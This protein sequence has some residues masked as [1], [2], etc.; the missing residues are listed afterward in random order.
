MRDENKTKEQLA[1]ELTE[2][3]QR[4]A[5]LEASETER[6]RAESQREATLEALRETRDYLENLINYA[7]APII[8]W[9]PG[10]R[11]TRFNTAFEHLTGYPADEVIGQELPMLFPETSRAESL[12]KI[13]RTLGGEYW[14][15]VEIPI[16]CQDGETRLVL[17]NSANI[18]AEDGTTL[19]ATISQGTDITER[20]HA[21]G[22]LREY[23]ERLEEIVEERTQELREREQWLSTTLRSIGDGV[24]ATDAQGVVTLMNPVAEDL[25]GWEEA[26][27]VGKP[28]EGIFCIVNEQTGERVE[29]PVARVL[30]EGVVVGLANHT[31][32]IA[33]DG[34]GRPIADSGAPMQDEAGKIIG[35]VMVFRDI[36][37]RRRA[38]RAVEEA[39]EFAENIVETV[40]EPL[41]VLDADLRVVSANRPFHQTFQVTPAETKGQLLY[42]LGNRQWNIPRLRELLERI[43]PENTFFDDYEVEH[44]FPSI[45]RRVILL[46]ARRMYRE[47][48]ETQ[49]VLLAIEDITERVQAEGELRRHR[50]HLEELVEQRTAELK[51]TNEE[52]ETEIA[53]RVR[54]EEEL[55]RQVEELERFNRL[56]VGREL[57][58]I[59]LKRQVNQ[60]SEQL[61]RDTAYDL[62]ILE[63]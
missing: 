56:A 26:E 7:N 53:E 10:K 33:R 22:Q 24:I 11:I 25:T 38:E 57:R 16:L 47:A 3:R 32:L 27:A 62:S 44:D 5:G 61:G 17:W 48:N 42:D 63:G 4:I 51:G 37:A 30:R 28:L 15:S 18:Y 21:E 31:L 6:T 60:L 29:S 45:G 12:G 58:M 8:I 59:E 14:K 2:L 55:A 9:D 41:V 49:L 23:S 19:V 46:N 1:E 36:T 40:R 39:R 43:L 13:A 50:D 35:A 20:K 52:L 34:T 54:A